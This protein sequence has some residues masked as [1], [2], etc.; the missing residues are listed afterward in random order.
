MKY[1]PEQLDIKVKQYFKH[2]EENLFVFPDESGMLN[3]LDVEDDEYEEM[4]ELEGYRK[5]LR[6]ARR[7]RMSCRLRRRR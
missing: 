4:K 6:W 5:V 2:C 3:F 1:T 7:R